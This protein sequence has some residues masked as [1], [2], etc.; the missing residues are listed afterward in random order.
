MAYTISKHEVINH[1][2]AGLRNFHLYRFEWIDNLH[3]LRPPEDFLPLPSEQLEVYLSVARECF[4]KAGWDGDGQITLLWLPSFV[5]PTSS[6]V[7]SEGVV[8]WHVKQTN[9]GVSWILSP[10]ELPYEEFLH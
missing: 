1:S 4:T 3:F 9:D 6:K 5:F 2:A 10:V 8:L 7:V